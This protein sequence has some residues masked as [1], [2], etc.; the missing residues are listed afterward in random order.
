LGLGKRESVL[1][2]GSEN[3]EGTTVGLTVALRVN[4]CW[5]MRDVV[6]LLKVR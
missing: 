6:D 5:V 3:R 2:L 1:L 4:C